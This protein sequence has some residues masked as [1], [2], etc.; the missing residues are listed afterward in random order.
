MNGG[1]FMKR[2][3]G[4]V[5]VVAI[6]AAVAG[7]W[8]VLAS[9][10]L[11]QA[12]EREHGFVERLYVLDGGVGHAGNK[13]SWTNMMDA[14]GTEVDISAPCFLIQHASG[15]MMFDT[16]PN[17][18][19]AE[20]SP[21]GYASRGAAGIRWEKTKTVAG[22]LQ[23]IGVDPAD[24]KYVGISHSHADHTGNVEMFPNSIVLIQRLEYENAFGGNSAPT[25]P[26]QL[27]GPVFS[28]EH[29][30]KLVDGDLDVFG[31]A[32]MIVGWVG[33]HTPGS[34]IAMIHLRETGWV[35]LSGDAVHTQEN[36]DNRWI[37]RIAREDIVNRLDVLAA[38]WRI[39]DLKDHYSAQLWIQH[40]VG[41]Y[42]SLK[43]APEFYQ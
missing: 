16:C 18:I 34:Q 11:G 36:F 41:Q 24:V 13:S 31:D 12:F 39:Q 9:V 5:R 37:P 17:D 20:M 29:P 42:N 6:A 38:Y 26:P 33:G 4:T 10:V 28:R 43:K 27:D 2:V 7:S 8:S 1:L 14:D 19:I 3:M 23:E 15:Y 30:V 25:G 35:I 21:P 40:D 22:Q 32:S